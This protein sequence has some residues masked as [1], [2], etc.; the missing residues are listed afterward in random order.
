MDRLITQLSSEPL[1]KE[2]P[3]DDTGMQTRVWGPTGWLF[4]HSIA[5]NYPWKPSQEQMKNY[6]SFFKLVGNVLP[7]R[8]CRESYQKFITEPD[9]KLSMDVLR[10]R[11]SLTLW[12]YLLHNKVNN[13]LE[14]SQIP[15]FQEVWKRYESFR[16]K[17][18]KSPEV[19]N[20]LPKGCLDPMKGFRKRC[21]INIENVN[22]DGNVYSSRSS[23]SKK[24]TS[25]GSNSKKSKIKLIS[26]KKSNKSGKKLMATF[27]SA[28]GRRKVI[29]FGAAGMSDYT[30]HKDR[31]RRA[32]Y[33]KRH[34]KDLRTGNPARA[35]YLSMY[36]L[37]NKPS[38]QSS[39]DDYRRRFN[40]YTRTGKF[41]KKI[42]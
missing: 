39:I 9:T 11:L 17:C 2:Q 13:K 12:L 24:K 23:Y 10:S 18:V 16:S 42:N 33:I 29:H 30:K 31:E 38:L 26:I 35:G 5:Q 14:V 15:T 41:P 4:L 20:N 3:G 37:W 19:L 40:V 32:R 6:Y 34:L 28:N 25:F 36:V 22:A 7:C 27:E 1:F 21:F 8:Y